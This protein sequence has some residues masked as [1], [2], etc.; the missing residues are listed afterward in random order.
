MLKDIEPAN[1][2][3]MLLAM[4]QSVREVHVSDALMDYVKSIVRH[5]RES[6]DIEI[7]L[8]P[9]GAQALIAAARAVAFIEGHSGAYPDDVQA[10]FTAVAGHRL[11]PA[12]GTRFRSPAELCQHVLDYVAIP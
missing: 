6:A 2:P 8:S 10:V 5:T 9:R 1:A 3:E 12:G 11:K 7:G 4:Q